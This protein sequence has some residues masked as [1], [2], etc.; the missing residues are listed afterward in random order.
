[1]MKKNIFKIVFLSLSGVILLGANSYKPPSLP[2]LT[3]HFMKQLKTDSSVKEIANLNNEYALSF[4]YSV[5]GKD[6]LNFELPSV[7]DDEKVKLS[8]FKGKLVLINFW[9]SWCG[10]CRAEIPSLAKIHEKYKYRSFSVIGLAMEDKEDV[11][12]FIKDKDL[13]YPILY[14]KDAVHETLTHYG[15]PEALLPYS[16]LVSPDQKILSLYPGI[17]SETQMNR[18]LGR[19]L[20][21]F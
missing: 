21:D 14:G 6:A 11:Q 12:K 3:S 1:M 19:F 20:D 10:P 8:D 5:S 18:V 13:K 7:S 16:V 17:I 4:D 9:A 2:T 15:N